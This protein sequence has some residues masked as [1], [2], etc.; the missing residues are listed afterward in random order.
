MEG[1]A[2]DD[3]PGQGRQDGLQ[4]LGDVLV[5][6]AVPPVP[7]HELRDGDGQ[8]E[9]RPLLGQGPEIGDQWATTTRTRPSSSLA[10]MKDPPPCGQARIVWR[11]EIPT[12]SIKNAI[13]A[14]T[15]SE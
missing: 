6:D 5:Q 10:T 14:P 1:H 3:H 7:V 13:A 15:G 11:Q 2:G 8:R 9:V 4:P 12:A